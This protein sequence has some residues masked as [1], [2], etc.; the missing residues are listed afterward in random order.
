MPDA[1]PHSSEHLPPLRLAEAMVACR[2]DR[3]SFMAPKLMGDPAYE[4]LLGLF[5]SEEKGAAAA[6]DTIGSE[7]VYS[8]FATRRWVDVLMKEGMVVDASPGNDIRPRIRLSHAT[9]QALI[10]WL[11]RVA[12][13]MAAMQVRSNGG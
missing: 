13:H 7:D 3:A 12:A 11:E 1:T 9:K 8:H 5:V 6:I 2:R 4:I 10:S